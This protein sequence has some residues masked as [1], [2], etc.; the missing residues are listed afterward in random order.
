[1]FLKPLDWLLV[2]EEV[3]FLPLYSSPVTKG[4]L[5]QK[6]P[7][8]GQ[9]EHAKYYA[10]KTD[11]VEK[12]GCVSIGTKYILPLFISPIKYHFY[13]V[14]NLQILLALIS[15]TWIFY[16]RKLVKNKI[17]KDSDGFVTDQE[18]KDW[19]KYAQ[20]RYIYE[21]A[22]KQLINNDMNKDGYVT[23]DEYKN[24]TYGFLDGKFLHFSFLLGLGQVI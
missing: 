21:D 4:I 2:R 14:K 20:N 15:N 5:Y 3:K 1:M 10:C 22:E 6:P 8:I 24:N 12:Y 23:W 16:F 7:L 13:H 11:Y 9:W 19:I 18:L 17:D